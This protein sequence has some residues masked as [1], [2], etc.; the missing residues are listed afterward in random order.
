ML[1]RQA[2][3]SFFYWKRHCFAHSTEKLFTWNKSYVGIAKGIFAIVQVVVAAAAAAAAVAA[4]TALSNVKLGLMYVV[5]PAVLSYFP[6]KNKTIS[7][8]KCSCLA[9]KYSSPPR[10]RCPHCQR[11]FRVAADDKHRRQEEDRERDLPEHVA[12]DVSAAGDSAHNN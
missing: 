10:E 6:F 11:D 2:M 1:S 5:P 3:P 8:N 4:P 12:R 7:P 9:I